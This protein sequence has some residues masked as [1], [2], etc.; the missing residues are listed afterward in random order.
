M[1]GTRDIHFGRTGGAFENGT[2]ILIIQP[3]MIWIFLVNI[4]FK[5]QI[6]T[7]YL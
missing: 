1:T 3:T 5:I 2:K 4:S 6:R 7:S